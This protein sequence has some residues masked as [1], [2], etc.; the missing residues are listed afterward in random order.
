M[1]HTHLYSS[2]N[3]T[4]GLEFRNQ[5]VETKIS[6]CYSKNQHLSDVI[7]PGYWRG[8]RCFILGGGPSLQGFNFSILDKELTIGINKTFEYYSSTINY[9][10][11]SGLYDKIINNELDAFAGMD[12]LSKWKSF[13][14]IRVF[15]TPIAM[16]EFGNEVY[17]I[18]KTLSK[19]VNQT[20]DEGVYGGCNS[21][22]GAIALAATLGANP[23]YLL[24]YDMKANTRTHWHCG[25]ANRDMNHFRG[26]LNQYCAEIEKFA[27]I[28]EEK[29]IK[30]VNLNEDSNLRCFV[31][32]NLKNV[33][34]ESNNAHLQ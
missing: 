6:R 29:G 18:K 34:K 14:G 15:I 23:I 10:M 4:V 33:L 22:T 28:L 17:T 8:R 19:V 30:V 27:P 7:P 25:Y 13:K 31:F 32:D 21:G 16:K 1:I 20:L 5:M 9:S 11:D 3:K 2:P 24:G 12:V 26:K